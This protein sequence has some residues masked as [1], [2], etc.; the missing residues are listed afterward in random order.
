MET[1]GALRLEADKHPGSLP[2]GVMTIADV[3]LAGKRGVT[4]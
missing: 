1:P 4:S 3:A 2:I